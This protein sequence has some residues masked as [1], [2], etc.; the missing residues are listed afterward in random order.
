MLDVRQRPIIKAMDRSS[1]IEKARRFHLLQNGVALM[2]VEHSSASWGPPFV[3]VTANARWTAPAS[4]AHRSI[5]SGACLYCWWHH[6][7]HPALRKVNMMPSIRLTG[8]ARVRAVL[9]GFDWLS[10]ES[11]RALRLVCGVRT[12]C[13]LHWT[14]SRLAKNLAN[15]DWFCERIA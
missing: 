4:S 3:R 15:C 9:Q 5:Y 12:R 11:L 7:Q 2:K 8:A 13:T 6:S 14:L 10:S 1:L